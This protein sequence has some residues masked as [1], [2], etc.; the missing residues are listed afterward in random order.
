[1]KKQT[2][3]PAKRRELLNSLRRFRRNWLAAGAQLTPYRQ[4][5]PV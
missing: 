2:L 4:L 3:D 1:M 5:H